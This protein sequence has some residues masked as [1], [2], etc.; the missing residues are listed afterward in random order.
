MDVFL[1]G[2]NGIFTVENGPEIPAGASEAES[3]SIYQKAALESITSNPKEFILNTMQ[4]FESY[5]FGVQKVPN[6]PGEYILDIQNKRIEIGDERHSWNLILG[7]LVYEIY[8]SILLAAGLM[9]AGA[10]IFLRRFNKEKFSNL[11]LSYEY[12][13]PWIFGA[14]PAILLYTETRFKLVTE[15]L[16]FLFVIKVWSVLFADKSK[17]N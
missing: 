10:L 5:V 15:T 1:S 8:R 14:I 9:A 2:E 12:L 16:L 13:I 7:N 17:V 4:K 6:L 11:R 3:N